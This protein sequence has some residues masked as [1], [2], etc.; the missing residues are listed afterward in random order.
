MDVEGFVNRP[1]FADLLRGL[2]P[3]PPKDAERGEWQHGWQFYASSVREHFHRDRTVFPRL[4]VAEQAHLRSHGG[5]FA[6]TVLVG[7]P[8]AREFEIQAA[9][10]RHL[11]LERLALP[12]S[13]TEKVC[14]GC[15]VALDA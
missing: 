5:R 12:P 4:S 6:P 3:E 11:I 2:R 7:A 8:T 15:G 13:F 10:F 9:D 14:E 1:S